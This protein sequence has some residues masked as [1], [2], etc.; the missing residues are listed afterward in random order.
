MHEPKTKVDLTRFIERHSFQFDY[1]FSENDSN[2]DVRVCA[3]GG[4]R[5]DDGGSVCV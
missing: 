1:V 4:A 5:R 3:Q 2:E